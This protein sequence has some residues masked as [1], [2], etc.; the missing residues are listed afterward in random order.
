LNGWLGYSWESVSARV[1]SS[2]L[3]RLV[4]CLSSPV[5][6]SQ[7]FKGHD[8]ESVYLALWS[9]A[10]EDAPAVIDPAARL[11]KDP[12]VE[13]RFVGAYLL[14]Q[15]Q[16]P[17]ARAQLLRAIN[18]PDLRVALCALEG[19]ESHDEAQGDSGDPRLFKPLEKLLARLPR[20]K[21]FLP[22]LVWPW[23]VFAADRQVIAGSLT[24]HLGKR[25]ASALVRH[26]P[27][28]DAPAKRL[29]IHKLSGMKKWGRKTQ[30]AIVGLTTDSSITVRE[31]AR[32]ALA[33][34]K[35]TVPAAMSR[36]R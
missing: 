19:C 35:V 21:T 29:V 2:V 7:A 26:L 31:A 13:R 34:R 1:V 18:D 6:R 33:R 9:M 23:Q 3:E 17:A 30:A 15:L 25:P 8:P 22:P 11:L 5:A 36:S 28:M 4:L 16:L 10:F 32:T 27:D 14:R 20:E 12:S 24:H